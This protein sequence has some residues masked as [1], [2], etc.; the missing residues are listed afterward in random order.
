MK[1]AVWIPNDLFERADELARRLGK[2]HSQVYREALAEY[3]FRREPRSVTSALDEVADA[4]APEA[5]P[6]ALEAGRQALEHSK[7]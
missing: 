4:L 1:T 5:D 2:A 7:W 3:V 6:W